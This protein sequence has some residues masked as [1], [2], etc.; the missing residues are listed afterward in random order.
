M[1]HRERVKKAYNHKEADRVPICIGGTAQKFSKTVYHA[2]KKS[3]NIYDDYKKDQILDELGNVI[4]Y[5]PK[6]LEYFDSDFRHIQI[7]RMPMLE[8]FKDGLSRHELG[9][10]TKI[11]TNGEIVNIVSHPLKDATESD[12]NNYKWP[13]PG[14]K[15]R[16]AGLKEEA[17][18]LAEETDYAIA[19]YKATLL[20][21]FDLACIMRGMENFLIDVITNKKFTEKLL[22][23]ILE[24]NFLVYEGM[25]K[26]IGQYLDLVEFNDDLGTQNNLIISPE[27]Y[28]RYI[29][30]RHKQMVEM[31][32]K[33]AKSAKVLLHCCGSVYDII[34]DFIEIGI[35]VLNPIQPLANKMDTYKLKKEFGRDICFQGGID[36]QQALRGCPEDV[37]RE[38]NERIG[39]E[40][41]GRSRLF[42]KKL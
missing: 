35:D 18:K 9:F 4:Y 36:L 27:I 37:E 11:S 41:T 2:I 39:S 40:S 7:N 13:D 14:D 33:E 22:D 24:F 5:N 19:S 32:K 42:N 29:K 23:K 34:P 26:E 31:F 38:V 25:L 10:K 28:R 6:V 16:F 8:N 15:R 12:I 3:L 17:K 30:H 20:G 21:I 1:K